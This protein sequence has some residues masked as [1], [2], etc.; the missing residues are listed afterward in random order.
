MRWIGIVAGALLA[1]GLLPGT[2]SAA[3]IGGRHIV[4]PATERQVNVTYFRAPGEAPRPAVLLLHGAR[5]FDGQIADYDR[6]GSELAGNGMDAYL[7]YYYSVN[8]QHSMASASDVFID[9]FAAWAQLVNDLAGDL[10]A[11]KQSNGKI[12][13]IG[14]SNGGFLAAGAGALDPRINATVIYYGAV[15][16]PIMDR[17]RRFPPLLVLHGDAD[18]IITVDRG[19][20]LASLARQL[21]G[22]ADLVIYP[23]AGHGFGSRL[24]TKDGAD[25]LTRTV[26]FLTKELDAHSS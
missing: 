7:V 14:F 20:E 15:P 25:A 2:A 1:L 18:T 17:V 8:D 4:L 12:G 9:R 10:L 3:D 5:G 19:K 11:A 21:G 16:F 22:S 23:G 13:L 24:N 26:T 6:Y